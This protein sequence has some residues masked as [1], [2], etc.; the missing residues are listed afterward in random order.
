MRLHQIPLVSGNMEANFARFMGLRNAAKHGYDPTKM[1]EELRMHATHFRIDLP[2]DLGS[3]VEVDATNMRMV[4]FL[5]RLVS[6]HGTGEFTVSQQDCD[7]A[8]V[9]FD[10]KAVADVHTP[11][12]TNHRNLR[13]FFM[14]GARVTIIRLAN[15]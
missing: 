8:K 9:F 12:L 2:D 14:T 11:H 6:R 4:A 7:E 13:R 5:L 3:D 1:L 15:P 10:G